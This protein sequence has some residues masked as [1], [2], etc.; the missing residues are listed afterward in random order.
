MISTS[1][2]TFNNRVKK[3][4]IHIYECTSKV[5]NSNETLWIGTKLVHV[6]ILTLVALCVPYN[7]NWNRVGVVEHNKMSN[8]NVSAS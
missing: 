2:V 4:S 3:T 1:A 8:T 7:I 5:R 6:R